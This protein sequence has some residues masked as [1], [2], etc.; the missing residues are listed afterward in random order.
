MPSKHDHLQMHGGTYRVRIGI[1]KDV[2]WAF[3]GKSFFIQSLGTADL[4]EANRLKGVYVTRF[5]TEINLAKRPGDPSLKDVRM[6]RRQWERGSDDEAADAFAE[7]VARADQL[8]AIDGVDVGDRFFKMATG[9]LSP[10]DEFLDEWIAD[11]QFTGKTAAQHRQAFEVL[12]EWCKQQSVEPALQSI[13]RRVALRFRDEHLKPRL[14]PKSV[15]RYLS[16]YRTHWKWL[17]EREQPGVTANPWAG[18]H[19]AVKRLRNNGGE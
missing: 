15:N 8:E 7:A 19:Q 3:G 1:P 11:R 2:R 18:T 12:G 9:Q 13:N 6:L 14:S 5:R 17:F 4:N 16:S 10:L